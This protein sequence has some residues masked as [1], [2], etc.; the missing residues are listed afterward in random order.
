MIYTAV[1]GSLLAHTIF[2]WLLQRYPVTSVA[3]LT[4]LSPVFSVV[5]GVTLLHDQ[6]TP[7]IAL[8]GLLTLGGV[9]IVALRERH[10]VDTGS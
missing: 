2:Y 8:G 1:A 4:V 6:L 9:V 7:R 5:F 3:P 10:L